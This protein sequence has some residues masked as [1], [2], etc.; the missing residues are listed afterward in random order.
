MFCGLV[1]GKVAGGTKEGILQ[2]RILVS[3][4]GMVADRR[5]P[6]VCKLLRCSHLDERLDIVKRPRRGDKAAG[7]GGKSFQGLEGQEVAPRTPNGSPE[8]EASKKFQK[9]DPKESEIILELF[10]P[11]NPGTETTALIRCAV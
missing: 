10:R 5:N 2:G 8:R 4:G 6:T 3:C 1:P 11:T 7:L 9:M